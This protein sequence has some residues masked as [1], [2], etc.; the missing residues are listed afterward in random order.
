M[1][2][3][4]NKIDTVYILG[5]SESLKDTPWDKKDAHY[6]ACWPV[7][8][9][10]VAFG[11][12]IDT[13]F[14]LHDEKTWGTYKEV[15]DAFVER[16]P[17]TI[18]YT[19]RKYDSIKGCVEFPLRELQDSV[20]DGLL[21]R[22]FTSSIAY[23]IAWAIYCGY[24]TINLFGIALSVEEEEYSMQRS[25]AEAWLAYG[26][27]KGCTINIKQPSAMFSCP[28]M[29]GYEGDKDVMIKLVQIKEAVKEALENLNKDLEKARLDVAEQTGAMKMMD[30]LINTKT[31][32][33]GK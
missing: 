29:Y 24:K 14:E 9:Q 31:G 33:G 21:K 23:I 30:V 25:C 18:F 26:I 6:M 13:V 22:Y 11:H 28:Y 3:H 8:T 27:G 7:C 4:E 16:N 1:Q 15:I 32:F 17:K 2:K 5:T 10:P 12:R 19:Q 20:P